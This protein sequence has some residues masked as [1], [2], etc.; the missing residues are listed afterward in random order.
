MTLNR[1]GSAST[2]LGL[3]TVGAGLQMSGATGTAGPMAWWSGVKLLAM[4]C[5]VAGGEYLPLT[6]LQYQIVVVYA[7]LP[8]HRVRTSWPCA[9]AAMARW[10]RRRFPR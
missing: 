10:W 4:P 5:F 3:M 2:A 1:L 7:S 8:T 9:W 6:P